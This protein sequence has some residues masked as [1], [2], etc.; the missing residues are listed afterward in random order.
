MGSTRISGADKYHFFLIHTIGSLHVAGYMS[1]S[2][3]GFVFCYR[4]EVLNFHMSDYEKESFSPLFTHSLEPVAGL[5]VEDLNRYL[6]AVQ[7]VEDIKLDEGELSEGLYHGDAIAGLKKLPNESIDL[8]ITEPPTK[9]SGSAVTS[10]KRLTL[11]EYYDWNASWLNEAYRVLKNTG[12]IYLLCGWRL[13]G[14]YHGLLSNQYKVQTR[15]TWKNQKASSDSENYKNQ[16]GDIWFATKSNSF[17]FCM[18]EKSREEN[19]TN[20]WPENLGS[21]NSG[22]NPAGVYERLIKNSSFKLNWILDPFMGKG[23]SGKMAKIL[24]RRFIGIDADKDCVI[25]AMKQIETSQ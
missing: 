10:G 15:L 25:I 7:S 12:S 4:Y 9:P 6:A 22:S 11:Q 3:C 19:K 20:F 17:Q 23:T 8:I 18:D 1:N 14:M 21:D 24:G 13:S 16:L 2:E 5:T